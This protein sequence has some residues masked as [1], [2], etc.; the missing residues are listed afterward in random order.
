MYD[1]LDLGEY[2]PNSK[3]LKPVTTYLRIGY[4]GGRI[5][6]SINNE[7]IKCRNKDEI[8]EAVARRGRDYFD[9]V[10]C[11]S[12]SVSLEIRCSRTLIGN[13]VTARSMHSAKQ[14]GKEAFKN[15][16]DDVF[17]VGCVKQCD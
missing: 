3:N 7:D 13:H 17:G 9:Y 8:K 2:D 6:F 15:T 11:H 4:K 5:V 1:T 10:G 12:G 16:M 14:D